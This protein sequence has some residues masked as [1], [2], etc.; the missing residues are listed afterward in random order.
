[1]TTQAIPQ[2][3]ADWIGS[4]PEFLCY[5]ALSRL[6]K[7]DG[8]DFTFQSPLMG[9]RLQKGGVVIDFLFSDPPDLAINVQG[10]YFHYGM[11]PEVRGRDIMAREQLASQG[12]RLIFIDEDDLMEDARYYVSQAL[13]YRDHSRLSKG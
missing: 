3:P 6:G 4:V 1:M 5:Q 2:V 11:G 10:I 8:L 7:R 12:L 13:E 9:G